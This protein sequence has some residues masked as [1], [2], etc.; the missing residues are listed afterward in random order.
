MS[1]LQRQ[2]TSPWSPVC[3]RSQFPKFLN[4]SYFQEP[5]GKRIVP[6]RPLHAITTCRASRART[7]LFHGL[8]SKWFEKVIFFLHYTFL[9]FFFFFFLPQCWNDYWNLCLVEQIRASECMQHVITITSTEYDSQISRCR[10]ERAE[11]KKCQVVILKKKSHMC[12]AAFWRQGRQR[13]HSRMDWHFATAW[14]FVTKK[15]TAEL[16]ERVFDVLGGLPPVSQRRTVEKVGQDRL[17][18]LRQ[19]GATTFRCAHV[20]CFSFDTVT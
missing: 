16:T 9:S 2:A 4:F 6:V 18:A 10:W 3:I 20:F 15:T 1:G 19:S 5:D 11:T 7:D 8:A 13:T 14:L 17:K 12:H